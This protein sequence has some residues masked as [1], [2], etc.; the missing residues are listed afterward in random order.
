MPF[1]LIALRTS[2]DVSTSISTLRSSSRLRAPATHHGVAWMT[3]NLIDSFG[4]G[5]IRVTHVAPMY[6]ALWSA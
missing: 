2:S 5:R 6:F 3:V 1:S 4:Q